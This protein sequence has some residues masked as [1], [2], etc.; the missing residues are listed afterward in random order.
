[1]LKKGKNSKWNIVLLSI[2]ALLLIGLIYILISNTFT[3]LPIANNVAVIPIDGMITYDGIHSFF[4][5]SVAAS[6]VIAKIESANEDSSI[7]GIILEINSPGGTVVA[8][9]DIAL[10]VEVSEKPVVAFIQE[11]GASGAY[12]IATSSDYIIA[13]PLSV[14]GSIAAVGSYLDFS[15][16]LDE[17]GITYNRL[18]TGEYKD[19]LNPYKELT[20]DEE[21]LV[22][23]RME[24]IHDY[25]VSEVASNRGLEEDYV[26][27][28]ADGAYYIG[29]QA[30]ELGLV[31]ELGNK[32]QA[33]EVIKELAG[34]DSIVLVEFKEESS[35]FDLFLNKVVT[36]GFYYLGKGFADQMV[37]TSNGMLEISL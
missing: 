16:L 25:F 9:K 27:D 34:V 37:V 19:I 5:D 29:I 15:G 24:I 11:V 17:Y 21:N 23:E 26:A 18:V 14:T 6:D 30:L 35:V 12:W 7:V 32:A 22:M 20:A 1:M 10:A 31:D 33:E 8:S 3:V 36:E 13:D 28:L 2:V 4:Q